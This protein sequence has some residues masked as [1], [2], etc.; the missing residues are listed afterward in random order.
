MDM[1]YVIVKVKVGII[2]NIDFDHC[3]HFTDLNE[4]L[5]SFKNFASN[6]KELLLNHDCKVNKNNFKYYKK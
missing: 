6:S 5:C 4:V 2:N 1:S 3:D